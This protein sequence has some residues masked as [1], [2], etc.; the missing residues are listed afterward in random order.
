MK[1][2]VNEII[3]DFKLMLN[4]RVFEC[5]VNILIIIIPYLFTNV[6]NCPTNTILSIF[7]YVYCSLCSLVSITHDNLRWKERKKERKKDR[8]PTCNLHM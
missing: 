5:Y 6:N 1:G 2:C 4:E 3:L 8:Q 7:Y